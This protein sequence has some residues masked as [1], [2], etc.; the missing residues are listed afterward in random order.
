M[1]TKTALHHKQSELPVKFVGGTLPHYKNVPVYITEISEALDIALIMKSP[2]SH[3]RVDGVWVDL[4][5]L[6]PETL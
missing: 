2:N 3:S 4:C 6:E 5:D 1:D